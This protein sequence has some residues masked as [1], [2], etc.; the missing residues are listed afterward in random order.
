MKKILLS[1]GENIHAFS[2]PTT[3]TV[4][5]SF[6]LEALIHLALYTV[7]YLF[8]VS[9]ENVTCMLPVC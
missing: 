5:S 6:T 9:E 2:P 8:P 4:M 7:T 3:M 1:P